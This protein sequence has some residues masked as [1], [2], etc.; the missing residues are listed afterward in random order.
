[1]NILYSGEQVAA[2]LQ[3]GS[4]VAISTM[5]VKG[6]YFKTDRKMD[7]AARSVASY[8][9]SFEALVK[10]LK[11]FRKNGC[12]VLLLSGSRTRAKRLA[13]DLRDQEISAVYTEDPLRE[14]LPGEVLTYYGHVNKGFE[15]PLLKFVVLSETD[16]FGAE[17]KKKKSK[18]LLK[19]IRSFGKSCS[20]VWI[21]IKNTLNLRIKTNRYLNL[22]NEIFS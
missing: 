13:E 1:M 11:R 3:R 21:Y 20:L 16:I 9:N 12:R 8:N 7:V 17:K 4:V 18:K 5:D 22:E 19:K 15:Y 14:V 10:D 2:K 6:G